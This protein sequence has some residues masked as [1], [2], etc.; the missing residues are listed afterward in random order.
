MKQMGGILA[1][2]KKQIIAVAAFLILL[3]TVF[4]V[5]HFHRPVPV[6]G[7]KTITLE[8]VHGD[9]TSASFTL[10]TEA[11]TLGDA[12]RGEAGLVSGDNGPYG[13]MVTT[14]DGESTDWNRDRSW[15]CLT[16]NGA[17][18]DTG[19]DSTVIADGERYEFT[20]TIG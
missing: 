7:I 4:L 11:G 12:L 16:K 17:R 19:V 3:L 8:V 5:W 9:G 14:V 18:V 15:W 13:L 2:K 1:M 20:Y 10:K 6:E